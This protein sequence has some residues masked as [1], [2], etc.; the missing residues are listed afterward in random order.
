MLAALVGL[1]S[2]VIGSL[3]LF[4]RYGHVGVAAAIA[5]SGWV[6]AMILGTILQRRGWLRLDRDAARRLPRIV[7]AAAVMGL[8]ILAALALLAPLFNASGSLARMA[9]LVVLIAIGLV[10]YLASLDVLGTARIRDLL[11]AV[12]NRGPRE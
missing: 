10:T 11:A 7:L 3:A 8:S 1:A 6:G 2:A 12:R 5:I 9:V 4:P